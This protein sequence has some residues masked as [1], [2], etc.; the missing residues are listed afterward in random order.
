M[1]RFPNK[2]EGDPGTTFTGTQV[3]FDQSKYIPGPVNKG[4]FL[5]SR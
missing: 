1:I 4:R 3:E 5:Y 2:R